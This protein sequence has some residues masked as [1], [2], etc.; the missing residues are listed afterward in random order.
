MGFSCQDLL[1]RVEAADN[2]NLDE[3][4]NKMSEVDLLG[5]IVSTLLLMICQITQSSSNVM[6]S[7]SA[8]FPLSTYGRDSNLNAELSHKNCDDLDEDIWGVSGIVLGLA[9]SIGAMYRAGLHDAVLK[10]KSLIMSWIPRINSLV[11][12]SGSYSEDSGTLLSV[13]SCLALPSVVAFLLRVELMEGNEVDQLINGYRE[14]ISEL[15]SVKS[16]GIFHQSLLMAS[17]IGAGSLISCILNE[18]VHSI[19][20]QSVKCL[21]DLFR[22]CYS[23]PFPPLVHLGGM[24]GVVNAMGAHAGTFFQMRR[25]TT[26]LHTSYEKEV[27]YFSLLLGFFVLFFFFWSSNMRYIFSFF[28]SPPFKVMVGTYCVHTTGAQPSHWS[29]T[30]KSCLRATFDIIDARDVSYCSEF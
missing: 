16:S 5:K 20:V 2:S 21:L 19:E 29:S 10:I 15:L 8:Y 13:G 12:Y 3:E 4:P 23:N 27:A 14:L 25:Q 6:E 26:W 17:C 9:S 28:F 18:G 11:E 1:T 30:F 7:L 24:L 22:K